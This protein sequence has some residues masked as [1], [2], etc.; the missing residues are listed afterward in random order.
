MPFGMV[1]LSP[2]T[3]TDDWDG[4]S[5]YHYSDTTIYGFSHT[6]LSGTGVPDYCDI[7]LLPVLKNADFLTAKSS[8]SHKNEQATPGFYQVKMNNGITAE[9]TATER[10]GIHRY[11]FPSADMRVVFNLKWRDKVLDSG[12]KIVGKNRIEGFRRSEGWAKN[13]IVYFVAD[14]SD[15][16]LTHELSVENKVQ[17]VEKNVYIKGKDIK[18]ALSFAPNKQT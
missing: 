1:Q 14:F 17:P 18:T 4:C 3:R 2:D 12:L 13:Q 16:I 9:L 5:G 11:S 10:V 15:D 6:H 8:F 7:L